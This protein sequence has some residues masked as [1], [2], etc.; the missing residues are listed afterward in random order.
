MIDLNT[1]Q[2]LLIGKDTITNI[3]SGGFF[4]LIHNRQGTV[5]DQSTKGKVTI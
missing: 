3:H 4:L 5:D 1:E 2:S